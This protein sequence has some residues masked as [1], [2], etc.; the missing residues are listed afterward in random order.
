MSLSTR[1]VLVDQDELFR[2]GLRRLLTEAAFRVSKGV[3]TLDEALEYFREKD[4]PELLLLSVS[5]GHGRTATDV[6]RF[7]SNYPQ[8]RVVVLSEQCEFDS[9]LAV[10]RA[11]ANGFVLKCIDF[12]TLAKSLRLV[13]TGQ[14]VLS[15]SVVDLFVGRLEPKPGTAIGPTAAGDNTIG[16]TITSGKFSNREVE[17]LD[18]LTRGEANKLIAR[19]FD[20]AEATVKVHIK[21]I[22]RKIQVSNRTQAAIWA[23][24]YLPAPGKSDLDALV[25]AARGDVAGKDEATPEAS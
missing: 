24:R 22:L 19:K 8:A 12:V 10:L 20:I 15:S 4:A 25:N 16:G 17:I 18:C 23:Q 13:M 14:S 3:A 7:K 11:G 6:Q 9:V 5:R 2:E 21:A 1:T